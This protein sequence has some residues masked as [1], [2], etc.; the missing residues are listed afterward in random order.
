MINLQKVK[1]QL[2]TLLPSGMVL[3]LLPVAILAQNTTG[4]STPNT[5]AQVGQILIN[6]SQDFPN[7]L[8]WLN[9][10]C[11][12]IGISFLLL[13]FFK[14]KHLADFRTMSGGQQDIGKAFMM[15]GLGAIF[16][17]MPFIINVMTYTFFG[18]T[19]GQLRSKYPVDAENRQYYVAFFQMMMIIGLISF[20]RGWLILAS[21]AK[22]QAQPGTIGKAITHIIAGLFLYHLQAVM[23][24][25]DASMGTTFIP[26]G[27]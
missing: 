11:T 14:L 15:I 7:I 25:L 24:I 13:A 19:V 16:L 20:I 12:A 21:M 8:K 17:W 2:L 5:A 10:L 3:F 22:S 27:I 9:G 26:K 4:T 6:V 1:Y 18:S 23:H